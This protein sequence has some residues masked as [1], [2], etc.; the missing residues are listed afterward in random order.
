MDKIVISPEGL[1]K[2]K[3]ELAECKKRTPVV[4]KE[5]DQ[6]RQ[7]GDL[8]ENA[9]YHAAREEQAMLQAKIRDLQHKIASAHV[10]DHS[11]L[12]A[13]KAL[14]G[15]TVRVL[16][17]KTKKEVS[18]IL[19]SPIEA[20]MAHGKISVRSPVGQALLGKSVG[21][22]AFAEVPAGKLELEIIEITR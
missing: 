7:L 21:D 12:D 4:A 6:A 13:S 18:Y 17:K 5:I 11:E 19:V 8:K 1:E 14:M 22:V 9:E 10:I 16:N 3:A 20:D 15:A 2:L